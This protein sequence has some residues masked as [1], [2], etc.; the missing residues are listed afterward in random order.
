MKTNYLFSHRFKKIG[1][2]L[3]IPSVVIGLLGLFDVLEIDILNVHVFGIK[4]DIFSKGGIGI[5]ENNI[6]DEIFG[7]L[8]I[9]G[10][11]MI[12]F[13]K[14]KNE[15]EFI[16]RN[17]LESLVWGTYMNYLVLILSML[18]VYEFSFFYVMI[19]NMF[20]TLIIHISRFY[21]ILYKNKKSLQDEK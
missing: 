10:L 8:S 1:W 11:L 3:F 13:S 20:T 21:Y 9:I 12:S 16:S 19:F 14:E 18:F 2:L 5:L 6:A 4:N 15:D 7:I 17:R